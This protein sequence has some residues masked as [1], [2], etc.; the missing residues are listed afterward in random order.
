MRVERL[1]LEDFRNYEHESVAFAPGLNLIVG[2]NAQGKTNLLEAVHCL[3]GLGSPRSHDA[4]LVREG[5]ERA[6]VHGDVVRGQRN[7]RIDVEIRAGGGMRALMNKTPVRSVRQLGD[8]SVSVFFGPDELSLVKG[9]PEG[10]RRFLDDLVV[11]L[12]PA[13][14]KLRREWERVLRQRNALLKTA[15]RGRPGSTDATLAVWDEA[16]IGAGAALTAARLEAIGLAVPFAARRYQAVA[17]RAGLELAYQSSWVDEAFALQA[18]EAPHAVD[19][20]KLREMLADRLDEVRVREL[21]RGI[22]LA[23]PHRDDVAVRLPGTAG[24]TMLDARS[25]ASQGDQRTAALALKLGEHDLL[26]DALDDQP[27]LLLDDVFSELD[28]ARR[29]WLAASVG[30]VGQTLVTTTSAADVELTG[31]EALFEVSAGAV[32]RP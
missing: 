4:A 1:E 14:D 16:L 15:P 20:G 2:P 24:D 3:G 22:S 13:R 21:E 7:I 31:I 6:L 23:G 29:K 18:L 28:P 30:D 11:K 19:E 10:R 5:A 26:T 8:A 32:S 12:R 27:V 9:S 25:H 17:R